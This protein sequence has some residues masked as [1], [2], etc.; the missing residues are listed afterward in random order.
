MS[1]Q[2]HDHQISTTIETSPKDGAI[3]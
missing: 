3:W 2:S 1:S